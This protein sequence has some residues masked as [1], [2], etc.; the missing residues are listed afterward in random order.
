MFK[1]FIVPMLP[2]PSTVATHTY[3]NLTPTI[4]VSGGGG[5]RLSAFVAKTFH[6]AKPYSNPISNNNPYSNIT[7][8]S[9]NNPLQ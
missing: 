9:N 4:T 5:G 2:Y 3:S 8:Y 6:Q 1:D 7:P